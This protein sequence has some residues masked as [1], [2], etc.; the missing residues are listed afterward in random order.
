VNAYSS[1]LRCA[2]LAAICVATIAACSSTSPQPGPTSG[3]SASSDA[4]VSGGTITSSIAGIPGPASAPNFLLPVITGTTFTGANIAAQLMLWRPLIY[5]TNDL[6]IDF[7]HSIAKTI[8]PGADQK[9]LQIT[10]D[11]KWK[12]SDGEPVTADDVVF[13]WNLIKASCPS[14]S[15]CSYG[16]ASNIFPSSVKS[17]TATSPSE[18]AIQLTEPYNLDTWARN[19]LELLT[20]L[21]SHSMSKDAS[22]TVLCADKVCNTPAEAAAAYKY[23]ASVATDPTSPV[24]SVVDGPWKLGPWQVN[25]SYTFLRND[26]YT[27]GPLAHADKLVWQYFTSDEAEYAALKAGQLDIG[28]VPLAHVKGTEIPNYTFFKYSPELAEQ[29]NLNL[30]S[31]NNPDV[32]KKCTRPICLMF[33]MLPVRQALASAIDQPTWVDSVFSGSAQPHY[34]TFAPKPDS[35]YGKYVGYNPYPFS[36]SKGQDYLKQ[37]GFALENTVMVYRGPDGPQ[38]PPQGSPLEFTF[39]YPSGDT[40]AAREALIWQQNLA[41][42]GVKVNLREA[43][44]NDLLAQTNQAEGNIDS[45]DATNLTNLWYL[46][47]NIVPTGDITYACGGGANFGGYCDKELNRLVTASVHDQGPDG[48]A[49][50][51]KYAADQLPGVLP[52]PT[53]DTLLE[54]SNNVG[55]FDEAQLNPAFASVPYPELLWK[56]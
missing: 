15:S 44:F 46:Y 11:P 27:G 34:S 24:W 45:W 8:T 21:P 20:P 55:G 25:Q 51:G 1:S 48:L 13:S 41:A 40:T 43:S 17:L 23:I 50:Y 19:H 32:T 6:Q 37:A 33:N 29:I 49:E 14:L 39:G 7:T 52:I 4:P 2:A 9:S 30:G 47:S 5:Y 38:S 3:G 42:I 54:V 22:G 28:Y 31:I 35:F 53:P 26:Q 12:W 36:A 56:K 18:V 16:A 10:L